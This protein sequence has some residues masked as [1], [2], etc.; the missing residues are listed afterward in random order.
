M[1]SIKNWFL[2]KNSLVVFS[3]CTDG[4]MRLEE[5]GSP[6]EFNIHDDRRKNQMR[7]EEIGKVHKCKVDLFVEIREKIPCTW[8]TY[9]EYFVIIRR[10][11]EFS[12]RTHF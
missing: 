8:F 6:F 11:F 2:L 3:F 1:F 5:D 9:I 10:P 4:E 7:Y 12:L